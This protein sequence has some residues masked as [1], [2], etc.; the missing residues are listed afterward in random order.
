[1]IIIYEQQ[2]WFKEETANRMISD[3]VKGC[4]A[5]GTTTSSRLTGRDQPSPKLDTVGMSVNPLPALIKWESGQGDICQVRRLVTNL[6]RRYLIIYY[7]SSNFWPPVA[8]VNVVQEVSLR[9]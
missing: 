5:I 6:F 2:R 4:G 9:S 3:L 7:L 8:N 1:M